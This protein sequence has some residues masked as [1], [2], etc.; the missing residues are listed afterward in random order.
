MTAAKLTSVQFGWPGQELA[1]DSSW[2]AA[3]GIGLPKGEVTAWN[4]FQ[5]EKRPML[6][7]VSAKRLMPWFAILTVFLMLTAPARVSAQ[8]EL[9]AETPAEIAEEV[10]GE[11]AAEVAADLPADGEPVLDAGK[12]AV[13]AIENIMLFICAVLVLFM[14]AGF[15]MVEVGLNSAKNTVN[16][17]AKNVMD[18]SVGVILFFLVGYGLMYPPGFGDSKSGD[19]FAFDTD[20][21]FASAAWFRRSGARVGPANG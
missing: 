1:E 18:L 10:A 13:F 16:I 20:R 21:I 19:Y 12:N 15:A 6:C 4:P 2:P 17:L 8:D 3:S 7:S 5:L 14:Q 11:A 9:A